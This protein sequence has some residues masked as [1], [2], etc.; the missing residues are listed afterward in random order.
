MRRYSID[1]GRGFTLCLGEHFEW[2]TGHIVGGSCGHL[3]SISTGLMSYLK[4]CLRRCTGLGAP[5]GAVQGVSR[6]WA[7][8]L[9][10]L[11]IAASDCLIRCT[12][13]GASQG[14]VQGASRLGAV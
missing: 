6:L 7:A 10:S 5:Q 13:L 12:G 2:Y 1:P 4:D 8:A 9:S 11:Y 3:D 14:A